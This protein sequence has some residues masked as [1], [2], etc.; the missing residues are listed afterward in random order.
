MKAHTRTRKEVVLSMDIEDAWWLK[1]LM[2]NPLI[3]NETKQDSR[4]REM[5][6]NALDKMCIER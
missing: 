6:F 1:G 5:L 3:E 4:R 2:Q